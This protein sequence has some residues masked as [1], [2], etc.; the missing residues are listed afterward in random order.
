[1][2]LLD[3]IPQNDPFGGW[4]Y[5]AMILRHST[6]SASSLR[7][8]LAVW[9]NKSGEWSRC[10]IGRLKTTMCCGSAAAAEERHRLHVQSDDE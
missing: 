10:G 4:V 3:G 7:R 1:L 8:N 6:R 9:G 2:V 5:C